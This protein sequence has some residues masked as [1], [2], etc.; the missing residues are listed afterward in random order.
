MLNYF[1]YCNLLEAYSRLSVIGQKLFET[2][3]VLLG[4]NRKFNGNNCIDGTCFLVLDYTTYSSEAKIMKGFP[5]LL[6]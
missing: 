3:D 1:F 6:R 4:C 5:N 2:T